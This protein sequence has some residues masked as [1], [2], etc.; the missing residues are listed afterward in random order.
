MLF[1][2][3]S[4][5][6]SPLFLCE[7]PTF[8]AWHTRFGSLVEYAVIGW[9]RPSSEFAVPADDHVADDGVSGAV[10]AT[11]DDRRLDVDG[12]ALELALFVADHDLA[13]AEWKDLDETADKGLRLCELEVGSVG[14]LN[15]LTDR[16][17]VLAR[18]R[19]AA[20]RLARTVSAAIMRASVATFIVLEFFSIS[21]TD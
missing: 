10:R 21:C 16:R 9:K 3:A 7:P 20:A 12:Q 13:V 1:M 6:W 2:A 4:S 18:S 14:R 15:L 11:E 17:A 8:A 19:S 5:R